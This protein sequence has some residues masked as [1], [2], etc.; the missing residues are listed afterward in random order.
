LS[1]LLLMA[2]TGDAVSTESMGFYKVNYRLDGL[3]WRIERLTAG[4]D[5][6]FWPG[7]LEA[8][9]AKSRARHGLFGR[10]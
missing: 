7:K 6:P 10:V 3:V 9:S 1:Y 5:K 4:F 2:S 8:L